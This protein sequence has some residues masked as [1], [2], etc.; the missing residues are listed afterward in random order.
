M[1]THGPRWHGVRQSGLRAANAGA[2][3]ATPYLPGV[4][5]SGAKAQDSCSR[6]RGRQP[7]FQK[8]TPVPLLARDDRASYSCQHC[9]YPPDFAA[10]NRSLEPEIWARLFKSMYQ[11]LGIQTFVYGGRSVPSCRKSR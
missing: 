9:I 3:A 6:V 1:G 7:A 10:A 4:P 8:A 5:A 11:E 2:S